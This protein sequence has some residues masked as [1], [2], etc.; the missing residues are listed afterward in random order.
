ML[1]GDFTAAETVL[2]T[3]VDIYKKA[4]HWNSRIR[5]KLYHHS[6]IIALFQDKLAEAR[7]LLQLS[8]SACSELP[9]SDA[10]TAHA[11]FALGAVYNEQGRYSHAE[12]ACA[13]SIELYTALF[14]EESHYTARAYWEIAR[15]YRSQNR[16]NESETMCLKAIST[17]EKRYGA[18]TAFGADGLS[19]LGSIY[20]KQGRIQEAETML[21]RSIEVTRRDKG[22]ENYFLISKY[23][24]LASIYHSQN[25]LIEAETILNTAEKILNQASA[26]ENYLRATLFHR[27]STTTCK[28]SH[29]KLNLCFERLF[30][31]SGQHR[32][33]RVV[34]LRVY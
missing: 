27:Q 12:Q 17:L 7:S 9:D 16:L 3:V 15:T 34:T 25:R 26:P 18:E 21:V 31:S 8:L 4:D 19:R 32:E 10:S 28:T 20:A 14:G 22:E 5:A 6:G 24:A 13:H 23:C 2:A 29:S 1:E 33:S 11:L 30:L